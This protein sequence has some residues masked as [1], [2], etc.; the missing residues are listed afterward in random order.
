MRVAGSKDEFAALVR[1]VALLARASERCHRVCKLYG[2]CRRDD[3]LQ[4]VMKQYASSLKRRLDNFP[5]LTLPRQCP[6]TSFVADV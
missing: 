5:G 3:T 4:I 2:V 1:E 6:F